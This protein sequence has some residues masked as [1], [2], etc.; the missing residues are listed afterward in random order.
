VALPAKEIGE[1]DFAPLGGGSGMIGLPGD[2][3]PPSRFV[4][5]VAFAKTARPTAD[6]AETM[7]EVF[8]ILDNFNVPLGAAEGEGASRIQGMRSATIWTTAYDTRNL[9]MNYHTMHNRRVRQIDLKS[10]DFGALAEIVRLPLDPQKQ[11]DILDVT[12]EF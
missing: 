12:P 6:G 5:A 1:L 7:Y 2:F 11:Q 10:I 8:R 9:V 3:T 4:R